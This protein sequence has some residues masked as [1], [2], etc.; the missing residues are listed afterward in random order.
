MTNKLIAV[1]FCVYTVATTGCKENGNTQGIPITDTE[2]TVS[3]ASATGGIQNNTIKASGQVEAV[4]TANISTRVMGYIT[5]VYVKAGD[6]VKQGQLL[7]KVSSNDIQAKQ[8]QA[9]AGIGQAE[10]ILANAQRDYDRFTT[11]YKQQSA[12]AKELDNATQ[13]YN[14]AKAALEAAKQLRNEVVAQKIYTSVTA[15]F[16]GIVTQKLQDAGNIASPGMP[17]LTLQQGNNLQVSAAI[18]ETEISGIKNG[19]DAIVFIGSVNKTV[20]GRVSGINPSSQF[21]GGQYIVK[22]ALPGDAQKGLYAGMYVDIALPSQKSI[23]NSDSSTA[24][25]VPINSIVHKDELD[26]IYTINTNKLAVL[27]WVRL[28][29]T[30]GNKVE[31]LSGLD[32][33]EAFITSSTGRLYN[34]APVVV[35]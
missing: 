16:S 27:R 10:A 29:K 5:D 22:V 13:Q 19:Q 17:V 8:G 15:P 35:K 24:I 3:I 33:N 12:T 32:R 2:I 6:E 31:V 23:A 11:L 26:G 18:A 21:T 34:G 28:G 4:Q 30:S 9:D 25:M 7:F 20:T 1:L 14:T